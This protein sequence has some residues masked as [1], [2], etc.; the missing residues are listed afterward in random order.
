M[1]VASDVFFFFQAEDGIRDRNVTGVQT[2]ALPILVPQVLHGAG[3]RAGGEWRLLLAARRHAG[4]ITRDRTVVPEDD[5]VCRA[6][7]GRF[8]TARRRM[9]RTGHPD[10]AEL[11]REVSGR[12]GEVRRGGSGWRGTARSFYHAH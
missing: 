7:A 12:Q 9:A 6:V 8:K 2:C 10:A 4:G 11:D 3:K 1:W 5:R